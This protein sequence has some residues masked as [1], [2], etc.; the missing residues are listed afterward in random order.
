[1]PSQPTRR[2]LLQ[3][4]LQLTA[5]AT[6]PSIPL[7][8][9][10][11]DNPI[12]IGV[13]NDL[14][15]DFSII[16]IPRSHAYQLAVDEIN[17]AGGVLGRPLKIIE[18]DG[19][20]TVAQYPSLTQRLIL[21]DK[22][23][24][25]FVGYTSAE[26]EAARTVSTKHKKILWHNNQG[27]GGIMSRYAFFCSPIPTHQVLPG[28]EYMVKRFGPRIYTIAAD[29]GFGHVTAEWTRVAAG[30]YGGEI[31]KE[32]FIPLSNT[33]Y[34]TIISRI[35]REKPDWVMQLL[36]GDNQ[37]Q[38]YPQAASA[39]LQVP[40]LSPV[41]VQQG[42]E[43]KRFK[44]PLLANVF[45]P[46]T[47]LEELD[48]PSAKSFAERFRANYPKETYINQPAL[49]GYVATYL[50][51]EAWKKAGTTETEA[52]VEALESGISIDGPQGKIT[53]DPRV[54]ECALPMKMA[55]VTENHDI[56][57]I[58]DLGIVEPDEWLIKDLNTD[59]RKHDPNKWFT[60]KDNPAFSKYLS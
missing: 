23:D 4:T 20:S 26:R 7:M 40:G 38:F 6:L 30:M 22:V 16:G 12:K 34:S 59:L 56:E 13:I 47:Y 3:K 41:I 18:Y 44:P 29:Y 43:H 39:G 58:S 42:Y 28:V 15:G 11:Q 52:V 17:T 8:A 14:T 49:C 9:R 32:E 2:G 53:M 25:L 48:T 5:A 31:I 60:P 55:R 57:W 37:S 19:Q 45:V 50:M 36:V 1:M 51:V 27:E 21:N 33:S 54:H 35:Q 10:A 24:V 46:V